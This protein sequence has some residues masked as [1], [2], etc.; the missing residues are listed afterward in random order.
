[1]KREFLK[2]LFQAYPYAEYFHFGDIDCGGFHIWKDL[3]L[4]TK[5]PFKTLSM[6]LETYHKYLKWGR[7]LTEQDRKAL[8]NMI[9]DPFFG[10]QSELFKSMLEHD[11]K[12]EQECIDVK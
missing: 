1:M 9:K 5:I 4:K 6:D 3:C 7:K 11:V 10:Y 8:E 2:T 12:L